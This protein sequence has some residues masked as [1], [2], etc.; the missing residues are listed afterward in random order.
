MVELIAAKPSYLQ[1]GGA[2]TIAGAGTTAVAI[3]L[4]CIL[5][6]LLLNPFLAVFILAIIGVYRRIPGTAFIV[7]ASIAFAIFFYFRDYGVVWY[8]NSTDDVPNYVGYYRDLLDATPADLIANFIDG[9]NGNELLWVLPWW[10]LEN[11][12]EASDYTFIFIHYLVIFAAVFLA[13]RTLSEK[14]FVALVVIYFFVMPISIDSIAHIWRQQLA[15]SMYLAGVG[16]YLV[17]GVKGGKWLI[18]LSPLMHLSLL[19]FVAGFLVF[20]LIRWNNGF[21]N[22]LKVSIVL[23]VILALFPFIASSAVVYLDAI[24]LERVMSY[25]EAYGTDVRRVYLILGLYGV[26]ML[27]AFFALKNDDLNNLFMVLCFSVFSIVMALPAAS[28]IYERLLM[29]VLPL[30][31]IYLYRC[32]ILNFSAR[33][34]LPVI[35]VAFVF[36]ATR[37]YLP[38]RDQSGPMF[39]L[40]YGHGFD[41]LMGVLKMLAVL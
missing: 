35:V 20:R 24:G 39:F 29:F 14:Y 10:A 5:L 3:G 22:K 15:F 34:Q 6:F 7:S 9:P 27:V 31:G 12:F 41:P 36:G 18:Y 40:A 16:L 4:I 17:R 11:V 13:L 32:V 23:V 8:F 2:T 30:L 33:W 25:L 37:L 19:F 21:D 28:G 1:P 26:P 38:T